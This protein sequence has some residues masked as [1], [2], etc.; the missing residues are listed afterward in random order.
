MVWK[1]HKGGGV[2][3]KES[4][5]KGLRRTGKQQN[6]L[7]DLLRNPEEEDKDSR[8]RGSY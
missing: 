1:D 3:T 2:T 6:N 7:T 8:E 4:Q 5:K